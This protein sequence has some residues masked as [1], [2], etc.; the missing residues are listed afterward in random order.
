M[1][2]YTSYTN[3]L[4]TRYASKEM[5][6]IF[7]DEK[8]FSTWR[9]LWVALAKSEKELGLNISDEQIEALEKNIYN[10]DFEMAS[11][12]EKEFRHDV[13]A[14]VHT[15]G[16][17]CP[18]AK[19]IIHLG[20]TSA[21]VG[22]NTDI[23]QMKEAL[24]LIRIKLINVMNE[25]SSFAIKYKDLPTLGYTHFQ[26]A[27]LTTVGKRA[28]L[29]L[30]DLY[31]DFCDLEYVLNGLKLRGAKGTTGTQASFL[32]LFDGDH[33][34]VA[35]LDR[36]IAEKMGFEGSYDVTGQTY[37][38]K[39]DVR[40]TNILSGIAQSLHKMTNDFRLLQSLK[41]IEEPFESHQIG[42]SA[43]AYKRNPMRSER[44]AS[45]ARFIINTSHSTEDTASTQWFERTLDDSANK[46]LTI[47]QSFLGC[48]AI[49]TIAVNIFKGV[50][51]NEKV[52]KKHIDE[53][54]PFMATEN[55]I[56]ESVKR[57]GD[58]QD[59]HEEIRVLSMEASEQVKKYGRKNDLIERMIKS[60]KIM[61][62]EEEI[63]NIIDP[64]KF[65]GR[66][67]LQVEEFIT[68]KIEPIL[69]KNQNLLGIDVDLK[70]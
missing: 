45:L 28:S 46:R 30:Q 1:K 40:V 19:P 23:I 63:H 70:V 14:H 7:S 55:I 51:V 4:I 36:L 12:K 33:F 58:R 13:M 42:S 35:E 54:L 11:L 61:L 8:K 22:D 59:L 26:P 44:I 47:P 60:D 48:D 52:I 50:I 43:M 64:T 3:P 62:S 37:S 27:Q 5:S 56:M 57:G 39:I 53:E 31:F 25:L 24:E 38:R 2:D 15:Y 69:Q 20:A 16:A 67:A 18:L 66:S 34:K 17:Q 49:L 65:T 32:S 41:E 9:K 29:W 68:G 10:I 6:Y 21:F